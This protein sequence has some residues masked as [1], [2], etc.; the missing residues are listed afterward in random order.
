M[1]AR[2]RSFHAVSGSHRFQ[3]DIGRRK[4]FGGSVNSA[5]E[6]LTDSTL[7]RLDPDLPFYLVP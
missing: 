2:A 7:I 5:V 4:S 6:Y 3:V 1:L